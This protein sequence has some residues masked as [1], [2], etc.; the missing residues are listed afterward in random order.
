[1]ATS[2]R[3]RSGSHK[4]LPLGGMARVRRQRVGDE[5]IAPG[6]YREDREEHLRRGRK[7][8]RDVNQE[9]G[10]FGGVGVAL[11]Q[12]RQ[13][14]GAIRCP[15]VEELAPRSVLVMEACSLENLAGDLVDG[16]VAVGTERC[17]RRRLAD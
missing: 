13:L 15:D 17:V 1:R 5:Q 10:K 11:V 9:P 4:G 7:A 12:E 16:R 3:G 14:A 2:A 6:V 8:I